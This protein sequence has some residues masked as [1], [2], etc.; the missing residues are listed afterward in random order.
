MKEVYEKLHEHR[1]DWV[2][3]KR[4]AR[5]YQS[6]LFQKNEQLELLIKNINQNWNIDDVPPYTKAL[7]VDKLA[8]IL[9]VGQ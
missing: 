5:D 3:E 1:E 2:N 8:S 7:L 4:K 9:R 6:I